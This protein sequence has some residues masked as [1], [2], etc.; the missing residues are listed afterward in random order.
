MSADLVAPNNEG[1][2]HGKV[3]IQ[4]AE[5]AAAS[6]MSRITDNKTVTRVAQEHMNTNEIFTRDQ[7]VNLP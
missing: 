6:E 7:P 5:R 4:C 1:T 3:S 2:E